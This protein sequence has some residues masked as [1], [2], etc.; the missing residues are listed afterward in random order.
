[1]FNFVLILNILIIM[2]LFSADILLKNAA[3]GIIKPKK[4]QIR[5]IEAYQS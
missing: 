4:Q 5:K 1:M 2:N 3:M